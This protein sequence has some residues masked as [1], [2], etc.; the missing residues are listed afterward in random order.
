MVN[1]RRTCSCSGLPSDYAERSSKKEAGYLSQWI[2]NIDK[3]S[4]LWEK[5]PQ[6]FYWQEGED[7]SGF[8]LMDEPTLLFTKNNL[9]KP[10][11]YLGEHVNIFFFYNK[12]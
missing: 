12:P 4:L 3:A 9:S 10:N 8:P 7:M 2:F 11:L 6:N 5:M 1:S